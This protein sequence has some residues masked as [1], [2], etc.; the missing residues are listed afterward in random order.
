MTFSI[1]ARDPRNGQLGLAAVTG[2]PGVGQL[3][4]WAAAD[5]GAIATQGWINPYLGVDG[6]SRLGNGHPAQKALNAVVGLDDDRHLRQ[7][8]IVDEAGKE[9]GGGLV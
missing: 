7:V 9:A 1:V 2:T 4:S 6:L 5:V 8:G 3:L